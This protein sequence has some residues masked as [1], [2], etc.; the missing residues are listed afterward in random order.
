MPCARTDSR[1]VHPSF[2]ARSLAQDFPTVAPGLDLVEET[3]QITHLIALDDVIDAE[4]TLD[5]FNLDPEYLENEEKY[6]EIKFVRSGVV[7]CLL[8]AQE[9]DSRWLKRRRVR[10]RR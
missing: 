1:F 5:V 8:N 2:H 7:R 9:R 3:D 10:R 6:K 4:K